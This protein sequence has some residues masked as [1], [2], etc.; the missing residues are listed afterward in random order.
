M[1]IMTAFLRSAHQKVKATIQVWGRLFRY[2]ARAG[3]SKL[4]LSNGLANWKNYWKNMRKT[5]FK[6]HTTTKTELDH[7]LVLLVE[8]KSC[9]SRKKTS[10]G[11]V[12][13]TQCMKLKRK[14]TD[15]CLCRQLV[16]PAFGLAPAGLHMFCSICT[17]AR[18]NSWKTNS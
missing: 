4:I 12:T 14:L 15:G 6:F 18:T 16:I 11:N 3:D 8:N 5:R 2:P 1:L 10:S 9:A 7:N 13:V 17:K